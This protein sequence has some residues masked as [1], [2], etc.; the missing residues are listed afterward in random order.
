[1]INP[2]TDDE[3]ELVISAVNGLKKDKSQLI[4]LFVIFVPALIFLLYKHKIA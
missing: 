1:M 4:A 3:A 2:F